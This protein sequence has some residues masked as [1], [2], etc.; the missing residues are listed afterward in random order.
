[1]ALPFRSLQLDLDIYPR[2]EVELAE[3]VDRLLRGLEDVEQ[4][5]MGSH[6]ELLT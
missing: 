3:S 5:L 1:M 2:R 6:L 4:A